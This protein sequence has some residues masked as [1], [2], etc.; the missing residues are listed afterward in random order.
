MRLTGKHKRKAVNPLAIPAIY[1]R[2]IIPNLPQNPTPVAVSWV[3]LA[4]R[5]GSEGGESGSFQSWG[6]SAEDT[7]WVTCCPS[8]Q[9]GFSTVIST[10]TTFGNL[11]QKYTVCLLKPWEPRPT[12]HNRHNNHTQGLTTNTLQ[13]KSVSYIPARNH[14]TA[15]STRGIYCCYQLLLVLQFVGFLIAP[16][17]V[18][19]EVIQSWSM[20]GGIQTGNS[21]VKGNV[22]TIGNTAFLEASAPWSESSWYP[23]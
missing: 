11:G 19:F 13:P 1:H 14:S 2:N 9:E 16:S 18:Y 20:K 10:E 22:S 23:T 7:P 12:P 8:L 6:M 15:R 21:T 17:V 3:L 4:Y 5:G